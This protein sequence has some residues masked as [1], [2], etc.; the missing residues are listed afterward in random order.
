M[1]NYPFFVDIRPDGMNLESGL[2]SGIQQVTMNWA[3]P[4]SIDTEVNKERKVIPLLKSSEG[5]WLSTDTNV[6]PN[7]QLHG[8]AGFAIGDEE[9]R[10]LLAVLVEG[11]FSSFF[12]DKPSP[13]LPENEQESGGESTEQKEVKDESGPA[14]DEKEV[15]EQIIS[16]MISKSSESARLI[17]FS[18][19][20]FLDDTVLS[21]GSNVRRTNYLGPVQMVANAV[22]WSL[23]DR[24][25][26]DIR[27]RSHFSRPLAPMG[28]SRQMF[29]EYLNYG[30]AL[31]GLI[32][33]W[34]IKR[35]L[36]KRVLARHRRLLTECTGRM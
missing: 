10:Q 21:I 22:D 23:E 1:V 25:L 19:N 4:I 5:S 28:K 32:I 35:Y 30:L 18:S 16:R 29:W 24:G 2:L 17:L 31:V 7:F 9:G 36:D 27:G 8:D 11:R 12:K 26:L 6:Q 33:V 34:L 13:L 3:S 20:S 14:D 15:E